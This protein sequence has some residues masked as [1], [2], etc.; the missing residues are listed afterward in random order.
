MNAAAAGAALSTVA[1]FV[2][3]GLLLPD[4]RPTLMTMLPALLAGGGVAAVYGFIVTLRGIAS[5]EPPTPEPGRTFSIGAALALA[6]IMATMLVAGAVLKDWFGE[7]GLVIR[8]AIAGFVD[9]HAA[10]IS[11]AS[12]A[13]SAKLA[14]EAAVVPILAAMTTNAA[15]K[16]AMATAAGPS[17][18]AWRVVPGII[19]SMAAAW[20]AAGLVIL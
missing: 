6:T 3:M 1:T 16:I 11:I 18:F 14:P 10:A 20:A 15:V 12:L 5:Q 2:Q 8:A 4:E 7:S 9:T 19:G 13:A 17:G